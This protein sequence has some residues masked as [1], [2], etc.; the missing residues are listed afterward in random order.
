MY[1]QAL[2][3]QSQ[4]MKQRIGLFST[5]ELLRQTIWMERLARTKETRT[6]PTLT[7]AQMK[8]MMIRVVS[9]EVRV[10]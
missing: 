9:Q 5:R 7:I 3:T 6:F 2:Q 1:L 8:E 4:K 10:I